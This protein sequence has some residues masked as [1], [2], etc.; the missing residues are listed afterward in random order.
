M[1]LIK[2]TNVEFH[3]KLE[4][5]KNHNDLINQCLDLG[6]KKGTEGLKNCVLELS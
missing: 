2:V 6:F 1:V 4:S 5:S 3:C